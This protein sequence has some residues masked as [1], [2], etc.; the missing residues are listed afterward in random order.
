MGDKYGRDW[1]D[2][3]RQGRSEW[4]YRNRGR[5]VGGGFG[6]IV[7]GCILIALGLSFGG[8]WMGERWWP[9]HD[10]HFNV[11]FETSTHDK[12]D[13]AMRNLV[14]IDGPVQGSVKKL[15]IDLKGAAL[16]IRRGSSPSWRAADFEEGTVEVDSSGDTFRVRVPRWRDSFPFGGGKNAPEFDLVLPEDVRFDDCLIKIGAGAVT[17]E[18]LAADTFRL[19]GGAGSFRAKGFDA[20]RATIKTGAGL[21]E[22]DAAAIGTLRVETGAGRIVMNGEITDAA[23]VSTG[24]GAV[25]FNLAG[26]ENDYRF[27]FSRGLGSVRI[28]GGNWDGVGN[29]TA[30]N[31]AAERT[32]KLSTG[33]GSVR[34]EF[35]R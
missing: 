19:E 6:L 3:R 14:T 29:G 17:I 32:I 13:N 34:I 25:E 10:G 30:G 1:R 35:Q 27:D 9:W 31:P 16:T 4:R 22:L 8:E 24:T 20:D 12:G 7:A 5:S 26:S 15:D 21:V 23:D 2:E 28:G 11:R 18:D 33:I